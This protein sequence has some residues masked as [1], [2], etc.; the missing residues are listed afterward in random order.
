MSVF[1]FDDDDLVDDIDASVSSPAQHGTNVSN[2]ARL[3]DDFDLSWKEKNRR[4][5]IVLS[6][7]DRLCVVMD[8]F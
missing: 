3:R 1:L 7:I 2:G 6:S 8:G 4:L 5:C